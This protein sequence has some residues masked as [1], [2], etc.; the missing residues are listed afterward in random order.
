MRLGTEIQLTYEHAIGTRGDFL[1][2]DLGYELIGLVN[3]SAAYDF[4]I[5]RPR[6]TERGDW[7]FYVGPAV[8]IG[9]AGVGYYIAL[10]AQ[11][12]MEYTFDF[13]VQISMDIRPAIGSA[14]IDGNP[15]FY[16]GGVIFG[17]LPSL[18]IRYRFGK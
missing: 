3:L 10:G 9:G 2:S 12:G 16:A 8:K 11:V 18:S 4:M 5:A 13:P 15:S 7:G 17:G 14:F 6:W 1:E